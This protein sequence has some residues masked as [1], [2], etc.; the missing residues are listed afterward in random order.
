MLPNSL[1]L[2]FLP[3]E[4]SL[5]LPFNFIIS[6]FSYTL[7]LWL[8]SLCRVAVKPVVSFSALIGSDTDESKRKYLKDYL[9]VSDFICIFLKTR[10]AH[11][12]GR[13]ERQ[14]Q[15]VLLT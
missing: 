9:E 3:C 15:I 13:A 1:T 6:V 14:H 4:K 12:S 7:Y 2:G 10:F 11:I 8:R 5:F